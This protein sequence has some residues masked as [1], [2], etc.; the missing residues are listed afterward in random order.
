MKSSYF[1]IKYPYRA[2]FSFTTPTPFWAPIS[3]L[4]WAHIELYIAAASLKSKAL[5]LKKG[6]QCWIFN[7]WR[8]HIICTIWERVVERERERYR[9]RERGGGERELKGKLKSL[10]KVWCQFLPFSKVSV[11]LVGLSGSWVRFLC[12][13]S[14]SSSINE[15]ETVREVST[16]EMS[17]AEVYS[18]DI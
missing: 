1:R 18:T 5:G 8:S 11:S 10:D 2:K 14:K 9:G 6:G 16:A 17:T 12:S 7:N 4:L 13:A 15:A 3:V